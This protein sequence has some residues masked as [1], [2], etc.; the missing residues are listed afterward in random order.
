MRLL[1]RSSSEHQTN[2]EK[3]DLQIGFAHFS[4]IVVSG[5]ANIHLARIDSRRAF[6][7]SSNNIP[8]VMDTAV[9]AFVTEQPL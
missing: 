6:G 8:N 3:Q 9:R 5:R 7:G 1:A 2:P 4:Q